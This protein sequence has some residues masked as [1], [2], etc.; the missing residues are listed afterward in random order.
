GNIN[1]PSVQGRP[2]EEALSPFGFNRL[3]SYFSYVIDFESDSFRVDSSDWPRDVAAERRWWTYRIPIRDS[4]ALAEVVDDGGSPDWD[5]IDHIRVWF[6]DDSID[7]DKWDTVEV[8]AWYF[9]QST[10]QDSVITPEAEPQTKFVVAA[11]SQ[12]D[13]TFDP[14]E[15]VEAYEDPTTNV[16][17]A[18][19]GLLLQFENL[20]NIDTCLAIKELIAVDKYSGYR[21]MEMYVYGGP[22]INEPPAG[23]NP[24][25][26]FFF[27]I[28]VDA[29]NFY[30]YRTFLYPGWDERNFV[31]FDFNEITGFKDSLMRAA[32]KGQQSRIDDSSST[33]RVKGRPNLNEIRY[34]AAGLV[35][36]STDSLERLDGYIWLDELRVT[37]VRKD[38]G[39]AGRLAISGSLAD[40]VSYSFGFDA[41]DPYFRGIS[42]ATR[43]GGS[44]NL[45]SGSS[46]MSYR[47]SLT[48][49][50]H[51]FLP[52]SWGARI[53][54]GYTYSKSVTT[55]LL[56]TSSDI[57]LPEEV[58]E[59]EQTVR[60]SRSLTV[61]ESFKYKGK[62]I[63][64]DVLLNRFNSSLTY[65][66]TQMRSVPKPYS[67]DENLKVTSNFN[68]AIKGIPRPPILF[69]TKTIPIVRRVSGTTLGLYPDSW[70]LSGSFSRNISV[71][72]DVNFNR[73]STFKRDFSGRM[74]L[75][76][77]LFDNLST[78][79]NVSTR[80]DL[81]D[82]NLVN[83]SL[84]D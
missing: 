16:T 9:V 66:R 6:E 27:R 10:W 31:K 54:I 38:V 42:S 55:P 75:S 18:Q 36:T 77:K 12:E 25:I 46:S 35:N 48:L 34:F 60:E 39:T 14:P 52:P 49:Q 2:D 45:G 33:Y 53:P 51:R 69:W 73:R 41:R 43:G 26:R 21:N 71:W 65:G 74:D 13:G 3:D 15:G 37:G 62:N 4:T 17:E 32:P 63:L 64:F 19:R 80:R 40:L 29:D 47:Y 22:G 8:A 20:N 30:E 44:G 61:S 58:R 50:F 11:A 59:L 7:D 82:V 83:L 81:S 76:Y 78:S 79:F 84:S 72:D 67:V 23:Q 70:K 1:D 56:R 57:V 68:L 5:Q 24:K 28:G